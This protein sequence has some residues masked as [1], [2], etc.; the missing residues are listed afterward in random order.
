MFAKNLKSK[1]KNFVEF[2]DLV[3]PLVFVKFL[4]SV[5]L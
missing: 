2:L 3:D 4:D 5:E 1:W